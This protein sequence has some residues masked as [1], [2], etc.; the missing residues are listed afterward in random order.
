MSL[1]ASCDDVEALSY[2]IR[3][4]LLERIMSSMVVVDLPLEVVPSLMVDC[5][6]RPYLVGEAFRRGVW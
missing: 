1:V 6:L 5:F 3:L 2:A 4:R